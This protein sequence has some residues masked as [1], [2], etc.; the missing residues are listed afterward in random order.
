MKG[1]FAEFSS[2]VIGCSDLATTSPEPFRTQQISIDLFHDEVVYIYKLSVVVV[3]LTS[4]GGFIQ[5]QLVSPSYQG[6]LSFLRR[7]KDW[8][9]DKHAV[10]NG[11]QSGGRVTMVTGR[12]VK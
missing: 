6:M 7:V 8:D 2:K 4:M 5:C 10:S 9:P 11:M 1:T 12:D 3:K